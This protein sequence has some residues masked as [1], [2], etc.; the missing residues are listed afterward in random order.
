M[1]DDDWG[2]PIGRGPWLS[3]WAAYRAEGPGKEIGQYMSEGRGG[4]PG[5]ITLIEG[6]CRDRGCFLQLLV[7]GKFTAGAAY[8]FYPFMEP[9]L[10]PA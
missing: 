9:L 8:N 5:Q 2:H 3:G 6:P 7:V 4:G 1:A 10:A